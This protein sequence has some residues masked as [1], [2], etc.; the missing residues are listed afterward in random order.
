MNDIRV[1]DLLDTALGQ[2]PA[3][4]YDLDAAVRSGRR[5][6]IARTAGTVATTAAVVAIVATG[7]LTLVG[8]TR[9]TEPTVA[10][11]SGPSAASTSPAVRPTSTTATRLTL[12]QLETLARQVAVPSEGTVT[13]ASSEEIVPGDGSLVRVVRLHVIVTGAG[14]FDVAATVDTNAA[15]GV[16]TWAASCKREGRAC[17]TILLTPAQG[18]WSS[19]YDSQKGR[20]SLMLAAA[21]PTGDVLTIKVDNYTEQPSGAKAV[22]PAWSTVGITARTLTD[23]AA[24]VTTAT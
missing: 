8:Q 14:T 10:A 9:S 5:R 23:A 21:L 17:T 20:R 19:S 22:G 13:V 6:R 15:N 12:S 3:A 2:A 7:T 1:K 16:A 4:T 11:A 24:T 18:V